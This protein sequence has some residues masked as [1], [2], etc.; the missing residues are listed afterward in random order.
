MSP[1]KNASSRLPIR[2]WL[3]IAG[4]ALVL[5]GIVFLAISSIDFFSGRQSAPVQFGADEKIGRAVHPP[6]YLWA[7]WVGVPLVVV[8][9]VVTSMGFDQLFMARKDEAD[10]QNPAHRRT[11]DQPLG[12]WS[13]QRGGKRRVDKRNRNG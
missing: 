8:G 11:M 10:A 12:Q 13:A 7:R 4:P 2:N 5:V 1:E 9:I 3:R 6:K